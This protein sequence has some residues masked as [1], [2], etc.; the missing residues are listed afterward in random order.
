MTMH[1][2]AYALVLV[3]ALNWGLV[4][5]FGFNLVSLIFGAWPMVE[6]LIYILVGLSALYEATIHMGYC[7]ECSGECDAPTQTAM[8]T[9]KK[10]RK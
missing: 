8:K 7:C 5:L 2:T 4:G 10:K 9:G 3:G 6:K 1:K